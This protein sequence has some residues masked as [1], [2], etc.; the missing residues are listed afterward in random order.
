VLPGKL[1]CACPSAPGK[2]LLLL[3]VLK[4]LLHSLCQGIGIVRVDQDPCVA[5][6][7]R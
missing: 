1:A 2:P 6:D 3:C 5:D 7:F 4:K